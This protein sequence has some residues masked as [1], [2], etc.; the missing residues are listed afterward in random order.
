MVVHAHLYDVVL[1]ALRLG[2]F[3]LFPEHV[4]V[5]PDL[6]EVVI[7]L[8]TKVPKREKVYSRSASVV[9]LG[10]ATASTQIDQEVSVSR[11]FINIRTP[12]SLL[13]EGGSGLRTVS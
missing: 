5:E 6:E 4:I 11:T 1:E 12:S 10:L 9:P 13:S 7:D 3:H 8:I 2:S